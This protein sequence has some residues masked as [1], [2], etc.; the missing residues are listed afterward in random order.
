MFFW[1]GRRGMAG[2]MDVIRPKFSEKILSRDLIKIENMIALYT[3]GYNGMIDDNIINDVLKTMENGFE[4]DK[5][6]FSVARDIFTARLES[7]IIDTDKYLEA[8]IIGEIGNNTFDHNFM[9]KNMYQKGVYCNF[10]FQEEFV[11]LGDYGRG[12]KES[13]IHVIPNIKDDLEA[14]ETAFTKKVSGR[15]PEQRGNGLKFVSEIIQ[16]NKWNLYFQSGDAYC[17]INKDGIKYINSNTSILG[18][19]AIINFCG[20][21]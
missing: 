17:L 3:K 1:R 16:N 7:F 15:Y 8:A 20:D 13:L 6:H 4:K 11:V 5:T 14:L 19:L 10:S 2:T 18:C 21:K 9:F 12:I